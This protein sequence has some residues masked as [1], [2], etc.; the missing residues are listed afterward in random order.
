MKRITLL[1]VLL[2]VFSG[3]SCSDPNSDSQVIK[4]SKEDKKSIGERQASVAS[5]VQKPD[6]TLRVFGNLRLGMSYDE[7]KAATAS[8][9]I[10]KEEEKYCPRFLGRVCH[11]IHA[12]THPGV[13]VFPDGLVP[14]N[15]LDEASSIWRL[16]P[17]ND[18]SL[19][20]GKIQH[21]DLQSPAKGLKEQKLMFY[22]GHLM[23]I[24]AFYS[25]E[26]YKDIGFSDFVNRAAEKYGRPRYTSSYF[27]VWGNSQTAVIM[28]QYPDPNF[29]KYETCFIDKTLLAKATAEYKK[30]LDPVR[31]KKMD[32][33][34]F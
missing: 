14:V 7:V 25:E 23:G 8:E 28:T 26:V 10:E 33:V 9:F 31:K 12:I 13:G 15:Y 11:Y 34:T 29:P 19:P 22:D 30:I 27:V 6:G 21:F 18:A 24:T 5:S 2:C 3:V 1:L 32:G 16:G 17:T 4:N 20:K